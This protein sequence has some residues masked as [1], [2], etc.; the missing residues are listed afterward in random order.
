MSKQ[1]THDDSESKVV[2]AN[3]IYEKLEDKDSNDEDDNGITMIN[4]Y[5]YLSDERHM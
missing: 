4:L 2:I 3:L 5:R 1:C